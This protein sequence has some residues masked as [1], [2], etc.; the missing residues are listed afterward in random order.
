VADEDVG[1]DDLEWIVAG[2]D[3]G[4]HDFRRTW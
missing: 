2:D 3:K 4:T 1:A